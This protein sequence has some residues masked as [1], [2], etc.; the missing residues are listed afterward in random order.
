[1]RIK[2]LRTSPPSRRWVSTPCSLCHLFKISLLKSVKGET[3]LNP[4]SWIRRSAQEL[5]IGLLTRSY[6]IPESILSK[7][8]IAWMKVRS[9]G[10]MKR[11]N[12][13]ARPQ[14]GSTVMRRSFLK[15]GCSSIVGWALFVCGQASSYLLSVREKGSGIPRI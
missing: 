3:P 2:I 14:W 11:C 13:Y 12:T 1:M 10:C 9:K 15:V 4:F 6:F 7:S 5:E 8:L